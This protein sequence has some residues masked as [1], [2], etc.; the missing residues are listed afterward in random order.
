MTAYIKFLSHDEVLTMVTSLQYDIMECD[1]DDA[2]AA[3]EKVYTFAIHA[4][5]WLNFTSSSF[6]LVFQIFGG[7]K[8]MNCLQRRSCIPA[9]ACHLWVYR[10][11][12]Y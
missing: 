12:G 11:S 2:E 10:G 4:W 8:Y 1:G 9:M 5:C 3:W 7:K 6:T